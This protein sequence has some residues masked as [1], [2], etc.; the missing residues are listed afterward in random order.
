MAIS[1]SKTYAFTYYNDLV[2][3]WN[4][5][6]VDE[7]T[8]TSTIGWS[9]QLV[10][11]ESGAISDS[12]QKF[13]SV[14]VNGT[15]YARSD[16]SITIGNNTTR[17]LTSGQTTI[18]HNLN[19]TGSF[20]F[21]VELKVNRYFG[22]AWVGNVELSG[23]EE[24]NR[25]NRSSTITCPNAYIGE[26]MRINISRYDS[27]FTHTLTYS[28]KGM[29]GTIVTK[30][31]A[32]TIS[33]YTTADFRE[34][35]S[36]ETEAT[37]TLTCETYSGDT[38]IGITYAYPKILT[39]TKPPEFTVEFA[40]TSGSNSEYT[41]SSSTIIRYVTGSNLWYK[42]E[43]TPVRGATIADSDYKIVYGNKTYIGKEGYFD[44][45][46]YLTAVVTVTDSRGIS[47]T[48]NINLNIVDYFY[49]TVTLRVT[50][51]NTS[52]EAE[53]EFEGTHFTQ[54]F[55]AQ[56]NSF[57][58][59]YRYKEEGGSYGSWRSVTPTKQTATTYYSVVDKSSLS[60]TRA[61]TF[62]AR[63]KDSIITVESPAITVRSTPV[64]DWDANDFAFN[65]P[66]SIQGDLTIQGSKVAD[67]VIAQGETTTTESDNTE[68][69]WHYTKWKS[70][71]VE[72][73]GIKH[74]TNIEMT[75]DTSSVSTSMNHSNN[76]QLEK[77]ATVFKSATQTLT[78]PN[79]LFDKVECL[80]LDLVGVTTQSSNIYY[81]CT[82]VALTGDQQ[83]ALYDTSSREYYIPTDSI[84]Y[85][86]LSTRFANNNGYG[87]GTLNR[88]CVSCYIKGTV[89]VSQS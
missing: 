26:E 38:L 78:F 62:Q 55:G 30:T 34:L 65:V 12:L 51:P 43:A 32:T 57:T 64:F 8:N 27:S 37:C 5:T 23:T 39:S 76:V 2:F 59:E 29:T 36:T 70:G 10:S 53:L 33:W 73:Y 72:C 54:S 46:D 4:R 89:P 48:K 86:V 28:F 77:T 35:M 68:T 42:I 6:A 24:L 69:E 44:N 60:Y 81:P 83:K 20:S 80:H 17:T 71:K 45:S 74:L 3:R 9:L 82:W 22:D 15:V 58:L 31:S 19:G 49:P 87:T 16:V 11:K 21:S 18:T 7:A 66:V 1:G 14:R 61:Y 40:D 79:G 13:L 52:G 84:K 85:C 67:Y 75:T 63:I 25:I 50:K 88:V 47:A 41:G 56:N